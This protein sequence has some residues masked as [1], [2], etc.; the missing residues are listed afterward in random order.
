MWVSLSPGDGVI[1]G[2]NVIDANKNNIFTVDFNEDIEL[3]ISILWAIQPPVSTL[4]LAQFN[5]R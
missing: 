3:N 2:D 1:K 4:N 5:Q